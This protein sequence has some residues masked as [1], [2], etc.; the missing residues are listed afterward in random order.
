MNIIYFRLLLTFQVFMIL[1]NL[2][3]TLPAWGEYKLNAQFPP[4]PLR[5]CA[6]FGAYACFRAEGREDL[7]PSEGMMVCDAGT[8]MWLPCP[9]CD[10]N[11]GGAMSC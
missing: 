8:E 4:Y 10:S 6:D 2:T 3:H 7:I 11:L 5:S 1:T 9:S